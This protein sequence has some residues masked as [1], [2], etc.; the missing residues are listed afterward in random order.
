MNTLPQKR[1]LYAIEEEPRPTEDKPNADDTV[2][3]VKISRLGL[4]VDTGFL[5]ILQGVAN[6]FFKRGW[7]KLYGLT[8]LWQGLCLYTVLASY[9]HMQ[10]DKES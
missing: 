9:I 7:F 6:I 3:T 1:P 8:K 2:A 4:T 10:K 5:F